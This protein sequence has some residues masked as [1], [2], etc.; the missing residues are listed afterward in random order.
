M[1]VELSLCILLDKYRT[2]W[3]VMRLCHL[4][5][6]MHFKLT[7]YSNENSVNFVRTIDI[8]RDLRS[9]INTAL[10]IPKKDNKTVN[11]LDATLQ[12]KQF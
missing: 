8:G 1:F 9:I 6:K 11:Y 7:I 10:I 4:W 3:I 5:L 12:I 2:E